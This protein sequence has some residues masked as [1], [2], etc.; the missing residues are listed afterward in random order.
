MDAAA[1]F[2]QDT[3]RGT[4]GWVEEAQAHS[5]PEARRSKGSLYG[6]VRRQFPAQRQ[7]DAYKRVRDQRFFM[8]T[9]APA[10]FRNR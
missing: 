4:D 10:L 7:A 5:P 9:N 6:R 1:R 2:L 8:T 3:A